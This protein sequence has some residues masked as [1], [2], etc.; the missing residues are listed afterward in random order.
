MGQLLL[1][2][3]KH[4]RLL[5]IVTALGLACGIAVYVLQ[6]R[7]YTASS[8]IEVTEDMSSQ[9]RVEATAAV[10]PD[11]SVDSQKIDTEI[12]ILTSESLAQETIRA[13]HLDSNPD[14]LKPPPGHKWDISRPSDRVALVMT[15]LGDLAVTRVGH[16]SIIQVTVTTK[17][18][19]LSALIANTLVDKYIEHTFKDSFNS[20]K[21][22]SAWLNEQLGG[23]RENLVKSQD[24]L[25]E[26][27]KDI[28]LVGGLGDLSQSETVIVA[29]LAELNRQLADAVG[30]RLLKQ[31]ALDAVRSSSPTVVDAMAGTYRTIQT[32]K[33]SLAQLKSTYEAQQQTYGTAYP[34]AKELKA[35]IDQAEANL[36]NEEHAQTVLAQKEV[37]AAT[38]NE[39]LLRKALDDEEQNAFKNGSKA[40]Q[41]ELA[42]QEYQGNRT[43]LDGLQLRLEEAGIMAGLRAS[44]V[45]IVSNAEIPASPSSP[46]MLIML[47]GGLGAGLALGAILAFLFEA[48]D[49]NLRTIGEIE[50]ALQLPLLAAIP[51]VDSENLRPAAFHQNAAAGNTGSWSKIGE[52]LRSLRTSILLSTPGAPPQ[53]LMI[54]ST[55]PAEGKTSVAILESIIFAL[56]GSKVLLIDADLRRPTIH[57]RLYGNKGDATGSGLSSVLTGKATLSE[58]AKPWSELPNLHVLTSG[59]VPPLPSELIGSKQMAELLE[60]ARKHYDFIF[61][62]TPPVLAVTDSSVLG[63]L[64]DATVMVVRYGDARRQVVTRSIELLERSGANLLGVAINAV[65]FRSAGYSE[66]YGKKYYEYYGDRTDEK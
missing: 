53:I 62:D 38:T 33:D 29:N 51:Q 1:L 28:G 26:L 37:D 48:M 24:R 63:H 17:R 47:G 35:Q 14:F 19:E 4:I 22:V 50:S 9:F 8:M 3:R 52:S 31:A 57:L 23:L 43:L 55:R 25:L 40:I 46:R 59:P 15:F 18:P 30:N 21:Q 60:E 39:N 34:H 64:A 42:L 65:D 27:Q 6:T 10:V 2:I 54:A 61:I 41:Y 5:V 56:N 11:M 58:A 20:T 44:S 32:D 49:T 12:Q 66:Y 16:T 36:A 45:H 7:L 13:L